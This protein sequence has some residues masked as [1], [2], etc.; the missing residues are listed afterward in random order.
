[1]TARRYIH[2]KYSSPASVVPFDTAEQAWFWFARCQKLRNEGIRS[3]DR[4]QPVSRPCEPDDLYRTAI[5]LYRQ[6]RLNDQ[7][8]KV[9]SHYGFREC[10]PDPRQRSEEQAARLWADAMD[11]LHSPLLGKGI[12]LPPQSPAIGGDDTHGR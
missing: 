1:M 11:R 9:M 12:V 5:A 8:I 6:R 4:L 3:G 2:K 7:H 10:P